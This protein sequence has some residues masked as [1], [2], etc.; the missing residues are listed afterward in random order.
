[1]KLVATFLLLIPLV[2]FS[3]SDTLSIFYD[4]DEFKPS[5]ELS[6]LK[7]DS[8]IDSAYIFSYADFL[9]S[10]SHNL[11]LSQNR[12]NAV[13]NK[14]LSMGFQKSMIKKVMGRGEISDSINDEAGIPRN[15][16]TD[17]I[18]FRPIIEEKSSLS[19]LIENSNIGSKLILRNL[20]FVPGNHYLLEESETT[21][22]S[23]FLILEKNPKLK[24]AIEGHV[25]C[26]EGETDGFDQ[27]VGTW[28][29]SEER[30]KF[31][32]SQL[33]DRGINK[34]RLA[35]KGFARTYPKFPLERNTMEQQANRRVEIKII[36]K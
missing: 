5:E 9:A 28:N 21:L 6:S 2:S 33:I 25:C 8:L 18:L 14:L 35:F 32:Y 1:M 7:T 20:S 12:A 19:E 4:K 16:R 23:L 29:L 11:E 24:I 36:E 22:D 13:K 30:A 26:S 3:Q 34:E 10:K 27:A 31:V 15:R 17:I